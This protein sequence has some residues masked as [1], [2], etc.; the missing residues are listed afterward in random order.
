VAAHFAAR[1]S[2]CAQWVLNP[3]VPQERTAPLGEYLR[4]NG[5]QP[6]G[7]DIHYLTGPPTEPIREVSGLTIIP[8]RASF[9]HARALAEESWAHWNTPELVEATM[10]HLED[11]QSD[12]WLALKDDRPVAIV[13]VQATGEIGCIEDLFVSE[14]FR[15][16]G[17]GQTM[18]SRALEVCA[19]ALFRHVFIGVDPANTTASKLYGKLGFERIGRF[20][21]YRSPATP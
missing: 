3:A 14:S 2:W 4:T 11:P 13:T 21:W 17:I 10:L 1:Q 19:R 18:M 15:G 8:A 16:Q 6:G 9:R 12:A 7:F 5:Y 20:A